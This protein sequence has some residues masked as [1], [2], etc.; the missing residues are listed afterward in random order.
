MAVLRAVVVAAAA[1]ASQPAVPLTAVADSEH[2]EEAVPPYAAFGARAVAVFVDGL[3]AIGALLPAILVLLAGPS[4]TVACTVAGVT[5]P[6]TQ[7]T[8][9]TLSTSAALFGIGAVAYLLWY[10]RS[11]GRGRSV[12]QRV[13][14]VR[15]AD[16]RTGGSVGGWRVFGRHAAKLLSAI[17]LGLGFWWMLWDARRQTWHDKLAATVVV[18]QGTDAPAS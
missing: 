14:A 13:A 8:A 4:H 6:C 10:C 9:G 2:A 17:P 12:G 1:A 3:L 7:P 11:A 16:V 5:R 18:H 15:I